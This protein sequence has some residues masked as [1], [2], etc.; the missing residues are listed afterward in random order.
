MAILSDPDRLAGAADFSG[1]ISAAREAIAVC[2]KT[3]IRAA[4][5][6]LDQ[7]LSDNAVAINNVL[8]AAAKANLTVPQKARLLLAVIRKRYLTGT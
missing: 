8:P 3:D 7:Y 5:N 1:D 6:A 2:I 4:F